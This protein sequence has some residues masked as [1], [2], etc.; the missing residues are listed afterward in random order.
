MPS[1]DLKILKAKVEEYVR[2]AANGEKVL[3]TDGDRVIAELVPPQAE[4]NSP[5]SDV[6]L[7]QAVRERWLTLPA[8]ASHE[9]P[10]R[11]PV[12]KFRELMRDLAHDRER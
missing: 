4:R 7:S 5:L 12:M 8:L 11:K 1:V 9:P 2:L 6:F 3:V 10:P